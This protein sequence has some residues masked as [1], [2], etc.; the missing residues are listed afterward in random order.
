MVKLKELHLT[1]F[2]SWK[3]LHLTGIDNLGLVLIQGT[4]GSGKSSIRH[5]IEYLLT[6]DISDEI[7]LD[8]LSNDGAGNCK[9]VG[10]FQKEN[11]V[12][13]ITK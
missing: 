2:R 11:D 8:E 1:N 4:N 9:I 3:E 7:P 13:T 5:A 6:D 10:V 12:I